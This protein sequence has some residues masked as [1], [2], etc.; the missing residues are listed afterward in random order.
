M[1]T[2][3]LPLALLVLLFTA[4]SGRSPESAF[5]AA[6]ASPI[7]KSVT[8]L[9]VYRIQ[10]SWRESAEVIAFDA[11]AEDMEKIRMAHP[12]WELKNPRA[13]EMQLLAPR[14]FLKEAESAG[15]P[16]FKAGRYFLCAPKEVPQ[17]YYLFVDQDGHS[18][19]F[20]RIGY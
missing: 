12:Y 6:I 7:P 16:S 14:L 1:K 15:F 13:D 5:A 11:S 2:I 17:A 4:C 3:F 9:R 20:G 8:N 18:A 19:R 10:Q